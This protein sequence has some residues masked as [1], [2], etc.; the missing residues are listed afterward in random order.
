LIDLILAS[1]Q[2]TRATS[3]D[4]LPRIS[5]TWALIV[6]TKVSLLLAIHPLHAINVTGKGF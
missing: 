6:R 1:H 2:W 5:L 3:L 4:N